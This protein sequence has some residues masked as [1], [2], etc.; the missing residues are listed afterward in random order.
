MDSFKDIFESV[1]ELCSTAPDV[2][3]IGFNRWI[4]VLEG[5]RL[6]NGTAYIIAPNE[7]TQK[8]VTDVYGD[9]IKKCFFDILGFDVNIVITAK[10]EEAEKQEEI[11]KRRQKSLIERDHSTDLTDEDEQWLKRHQDS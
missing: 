11:E 1:K 7:F 2:S 3:S 6:E 9:V 8:T 4:K 5:D 10:N